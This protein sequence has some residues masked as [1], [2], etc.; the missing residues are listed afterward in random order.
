M[1]STAEPTGS[2]SSTGAA[3]SSSATAFYRN[4]TGLVRGVSP[5]SAFVFQFIGAHPAYPLAYGL[6]FAFALFP[7]GNFLVAGLLTIPLV[8]AF[9]YSYG[10]LTRIMPRTGGDYLFVSRILSPSVGIVSS[11]SF[12]VGQLLSLAFFG[13]AVTTLGIAPGMTVVGLITHSS[14]LVNASATISASHGWQFLIG[15]V[16]FTI[17]AVI[18]VGGWKIT[19]R[20]QNVI[21]AMLTLCFVICVITALVIPHQSFIT[22]FNSFARPYTHLGNTYQSAITSANKAGIDTNP[23]FSF[24]NTIPLVGIFASFAI[25]TWFAAY[26]GSEL[27]QARTTRQAHMMALAGTVAVVLVAVFA[28]LF[29]N[30]FGSAFLIA[31]NSSTG[32]PSGIGFAPTYIF[33]TS[34]AVGSTPLAI[35][36]II[37]FISYFA[38]PVYQIDLTL[39]RTIFAYSFDGLL[40]RRLSSVEERTRTPWWAI[41]ITWVLTELVFLISLQLGNFFQILVYATLIF[42][43]SMA[44]VGA[45]ALVVP[46]RKP[47]LYRA[48]AT[49]RRVFG[50]PVISIAGGFAVVSVALIWTIYFVWPTQFGLENT[51]QFLLWVIGTILAAVVFFNLARYIQR[52]RGIRVELAYAEIPPE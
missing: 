8:L 20:I 22:D 18:L 7:G 6:F 13:A 33:L 36:L 39:T 37:C 30:Q 25:Y 3:A 15:S 10:L 44:F 1:S 24:T 28:L 52:R 26:A 31:A 21:F 5:R 11:F 19:L 32:L 27:R 29:I 45:C 49:Q 2:Q 16:L 12:A 35:I 43:I 14:W 34:A 50:I 40:P 41:A 51:T 48:G 42:S 38:V 47:E 4:A 46:W 17:G 23:G 9:A